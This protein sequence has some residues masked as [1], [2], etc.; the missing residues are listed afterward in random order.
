MVKRTFTVRDKNVILQ[1]YKSLV[2]PHLEYSVQAWRPHF[3]KDIDLLE[4]VQ[5]RATKLITAIKDEA[6]EDRLRH[7][8]LTTLETRRLRGDLIEVFKIFKGFDD[9]DPN[10]FFE[11]SQANTRGHSLKLIKPRCRLDIRKFSFAHRVVDIWNNLD[12]GIVACDSING[13]KNRIDK[14]LNGRGFI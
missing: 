10:M 7:V 12:E 4:G 9:L 14:Y 3:R 11:L 13:F 5:R 2:R 6:Y 8:N 1:L